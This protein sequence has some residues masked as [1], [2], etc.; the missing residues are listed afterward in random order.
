MTG[1][2]EQFD[3]IVLGLGKTGLSIVDYYLSRGKS[4]LAMDSGMSSEKAREIGKKY[5]GLEIAL[6]EFE[7]ETLCRAREIVISPGVPLSNPAIQAAIS[8]G[9]ELN[10]DI[11]IFCREVSKPVLAV[12]GSNGKST[13]ATLL[14]QMIRE[15]GHTAS[16]AG[17]IGKPVLQLLDE[18][19]SDYYVL[20]LSSFQL[21]SLQSLDARVAVVL[22]VSEDHMDRYDSYAE[23]AATKKKIYRGHGTLIL[24]RDDPTV[25]AMA[26]A[27]R[28]LVSFG[29]SEPGAEDLGIEKQN[30]EL[31]LCYGQKKLLKANELHNQATHNIANALAALAMGR[32]INLPWE[33]MLSALREFTGLPHRCQCL[34]N[35]ASVDWYNDSKGTNVG[36][37]CAAIKGLAGEGSLVLI[38]GG[39]GKGA[40]FA[41]LAETVREFVKAVVLIGKD[42]Q[43]IASALDENTERY[44]ALNMESAVN[45]A[46][47]LAETG[48]RVL[49]SPACA[50][51]DMYRDYQHRGN[52][53]QA[54]VEALGESTNE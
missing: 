19:I 39:D 41:P 44:F 2:L 6:G 46:A 47:T 14:T 42:A 17:N 50:S 20:E 18:E 40:D 21:E 28:N 51:Q 33:P 27:D 43:L 3:S 36:A 23:Y 48:G 32:A 54:A 11:E 37:S 49:L 35:I 7:S 24:N 25:M 45:T 5:P 8:S 34:G 15:C 4:L 29:L 52:E 16:L 31:V 53:F 22:N 13:V 10:S 26:E 38:A 9:V 30:G 1:S 12:T